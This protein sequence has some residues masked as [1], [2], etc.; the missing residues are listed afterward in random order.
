[1]IY[2]PTFNE[3]KNCVFRNVYPVIFANSSLGRKPM[4]SYRSLCL[5]F[6]HPYSFSA[7]L[8]LPSSLTI[9]P[10][11]LLLHPDLTSATTPILSL[12]ALLQH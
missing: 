4:V 2:T 8:K 9:P 1:M 12:M 3:N 6:S 5:I 7:L 10:L 11:P